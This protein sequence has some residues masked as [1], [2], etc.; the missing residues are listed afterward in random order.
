MNTIN[1][2]IVAICTLF[3][4]VGKNVLPYSG[5]L[6][7]P[8]VPCFI[9]LARMCFHTLDYYCRHM[10]PVLL[11]WQECASILWI[12]IV[13]ICTLFYCVGKNV[14]PYSGLLL[15]P[16]VP[17][18]IVLARM[19]FHTLDYYC[20]HMYPVL[21]CWQECA[22]ILWIIIV[23]ICTLFYCVGKN[24]LPY[25]GLL[26]SPYVP[27][28]IVLART[29]SGSHTAFGVLAFHPSS[30]LLACPDLICFNHSDCCNRF[31]LFLS[32]HSTKQDIRIR[33]QC[34]CAKTHVV[35]TLRSVHI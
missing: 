12:I 27:C 18:F 25:S 4:C 32:F 31:L 6:L 14:L 10:Y 16:Y 30:V 9:V 28:F 8:Y 1:I 20:R 33:C 19:C 22:P 3:Y 7:S 11:C 15:S 29:C 34:N 24:V 2:I 21:L 17:C 26:L 13:A 23:A 5:L 35:I